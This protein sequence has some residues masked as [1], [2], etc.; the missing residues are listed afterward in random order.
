MTKLRALP[1]RRKSSAITPIEP[2]IRQF[3]KDRNLVVLR[4]KS[5][6]LPLNVS[7]TIDG[8][9]W[10]ANSCGKLLFFRN[11]QLRTRVIDGIRQPYFHA[12][13][14]K[15]F[16]KSNKVYVE[17][18]VPKDHYRPDGTLDSRKQVAEYSWGHKGLKMLYHTISS[19]ER[20]RL[21]YSSRNKKPS[22]A[23]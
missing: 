20:T 14:S 13:D 11:A 4:R 18:F 7:Y 12:L 3:I 1:K 9:R 19:E 22:R 2:W 21:I 23:A 10:T 6:G 16:E 15:G 5:D 17:H 8:L